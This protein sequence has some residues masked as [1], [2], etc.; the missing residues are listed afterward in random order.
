MTFITAGLAIAGLAAMALPIL[1]HLLSRQ[2][3][4]PIAWAAM[5]FLLE[6]FKKHRRRL[7][8][9]QIILLALRCLIIALIGFALARPLLEQSGILNVGGSRAIFLVVDN[10]LISGL[11][12]GNQEIELKENVDHA[13]EL[14]G[15]LDVGDAVGVITSARPARGL[16]VPPSSDHGAVIDILNE[17]KPSHSPS[18][19]PGALTMV[20]QAVLNLDDRYDEVQVYLL[21]GFREGSAALNSPLSDVFGDFER[22][23]TL[24]ASSPADVAV[25]NIQIVDLKPVRSLILSG[26]LDGSG[27]IAVKLLRH[28]AVLDQELTQVR[29]AGDGI[30]NIPAKTLRWE[31]GQSEAQVDFTLDFAVSGNRKIGLTVTIDNDALDADNERYTVIELRDEI[32]VLLIDRRSFGFEPSIDRMPAGT[33]IRRA[34][35]PSDESPIEVVSVEPMALDVIDLRSADA[36]VL[37]RPDLLPDSSW[38]MLR[39]FVDAGGLLII[40]PPGDLNIHAW[41]DHLSEELDLPWRIALEVQEFEEGITLA[42]EQPKS[43]LLRMISSD[44]ES[45]LSPVVT[46]RRLPLDLEQSQPQIVLEFNDGS[47]MVVIGMPGSGGDESEIDGTEVSG[48]FSRGLVVYMAVAP[49]LAWS[50]LPTKPFMVPLFQEIIRQGLSETRTSQ[51]IVVGEQQAIARGSVVRDL[52]DPEGELLPL[53]A[54][55]RPQNPFS[56]EGMYELLDRGSRPVGILAVNVEPRA[57][58]SQTQDPEAVQAWLSGSGEW[59]QFNPDNLKAALLTSRAGS[60]LAGILLWI[61]LALVVLETLLSRW[62]SHALRTAASEER[63]GGLRASVDVMTSSGRSGS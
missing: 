21:S 49:E 29:L 60:S 37:P 3:R 61:V 42:T 39:D 40:T 47:P 63:F 27:Q 6:A 48:T 8:L 9:E 55:G 28:G 41:A 5:R 14:I 32:R 50:N 17:L 45:L 24:L 18:D 11:K 33:W 2:R 4:K 31:P 30:V 12:V 19:I 35:E 62:F 56:M 7:Q 34:L 57:G 52:V 36:A 23:V 54:N 25:T 26:V 1:I 10:G 51:R 44:L 46:F 16:L 53:D 43:E 38:S 15:V 58:R 22:S 20:K 59:M 13:V